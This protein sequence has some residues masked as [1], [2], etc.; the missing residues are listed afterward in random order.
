[1]TKTT[2]GTGRATVA[3]VMHHGVITCPPQAT[4]ADVAA[5]MAHHCVHSVVVRGLARGPRG[6]E[7]MVWGIVSDMDLMRAA[8]AGEM[9]VQADAIAATEIVTIGGEDDLT[10]VAQLMSEHE[11]SHLIVV[12][13]T[14]DPVGVISS[15]DV[16]GALAPALRSG[17][18]GA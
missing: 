15:L 12:S 1:M 4:L 11:L 5:R 8:A 9:D 13:A 3:A 10:T 16:A 6:S 17:G 7:R 2:T 18:R 14:G